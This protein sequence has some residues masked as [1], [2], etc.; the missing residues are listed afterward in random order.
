MFDISRKENSC[1]L[2]FCTSI[3][4]RPVPMRHITFQSYFKIM[5]LKHSF[6]FESFPFFYTNS[7]STDTKCGKN[8]LL[9]SCACAYVQMTDAIPEIKNNYLQT[10]N[11]GYELFKKVTVQSKVLRRF[12]LCCTL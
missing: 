6:C 2:Q 4:Y 10:K 7:F 11:E 8:C 12:C 9:V 1:E 5:F 3:S